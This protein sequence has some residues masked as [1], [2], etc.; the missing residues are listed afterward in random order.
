M[1]ASTRSD[2][3]DNSVSDDASKKR[4]SRLLESLGS[5]THKR[6]K[7]MPLDPY[8]KFAAWYTRSQNAFANYGLVLDAGLAWEN[9]EFGGL[10][11]DQFY[12]ENEEDLRVYLHFA[13]KLPQFAKDFYALQEQPEEI[14]NLAKLLN[15]AVTAARGADISS[16][17]EA[18]LEYVA[19]EEANEILLPKIRH[20]ADKKTTRGYNHPVLARLLCPVKYL[21][22]FDAEPEEFRKKLLRNQVKVLSGD[23][24][25]L[26]YAS[27]DIDPDD[28]ESG[29]LRSR[30]LLRV[31]KHIFTAPTSAK[32][33]IA[34]PKKTK[35]KKTQAQLNN[36]K[37]VTPGSIVYAA[38]MYRHSISALDD[39]RTEDDLFDR[40]QFAKSL[41]DAFYDTEDTWTKDTL[42]WWNAH[43]FGTLAEPEDQD[44]DREPSTADLIRQKR[45]NRKTERNAGRAQPAVRE[46]NDAVEEETPPSS[47]AQRDL[48]DS[49]SDIYNNGSSQIYERQ[50]K[51]C[52]AGSSRHQQP[53]PANRLSNPQHNIQT[54]SPLAD[55]DNMP[56]RQKRLHH[57]DSLR[58]RSA[59]PSHPARHLTSRS[60]SPKQRHPQ[61][62]PPRPSHHNEL[63]RR[64][65]S[66]SRHGYDSSRGGQSQTVFR[67]GQSPSRYALETASWD[68]PRHSHAPR[69]SLQQAEPLS[70]PSL[71]IPG[72]VKA[73][74]R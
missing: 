74:T 7:T 53:S 41:M 25:T 40:N 30:V 10:T 36:M 65:Q 44:Q 11:Q 37:T 60:R 71:R 72:Q 49:L 61:S 55:Y 17:R 42:A 47:S 66:S 43:V 18:G 64:D 14:E 6:K 28:P 21:P 5:R 24:P 63:P 22:E 9:K 50:T 27:H 16:L 23:Y 46:G 68:A 57:S 32:E 34:A 15:E 52:A 19:L 69:A 38:L 1:S 12:D 8:K 62:S 45:A 39:W 67:S 56:P 2:D 58:H 54:R 35:T 29:L 73:I 4:K 70:L 51:Y 20:G 13:T 26:L 33:D 59:L 3:E 31:F 48:D